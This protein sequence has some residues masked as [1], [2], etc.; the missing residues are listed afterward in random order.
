[1]KRSRVDLV[2]LGDSAC[3]RVYRGIDY[4]GGGSGIVGRAAMAIMDAT[5][6]DPVRYAH[7]ALMIIRT[8]QTG[9]KP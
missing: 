2:P 5:Q 6:D 4:Y 8:I 3:L 9:A 1:M 7:A